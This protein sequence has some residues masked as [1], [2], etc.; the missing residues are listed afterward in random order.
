M[1]KIP[2]IF[3]LPFELS[4]PSYT[5]TST[6]HARLSTRCSPASQEQISI[7]K[8]HDTPTSASVQVISLFI[9]LVI[10]AISQPNLKLTRARMIEPP[11]LDIVLALEWV[12][13]ARAT[14][15]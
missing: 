5:S 15:A 8:S 14:E 10:R 1:L 12:V 4:N 13:L 7:Y 3:L 11:T 6:R 9:E 2:R